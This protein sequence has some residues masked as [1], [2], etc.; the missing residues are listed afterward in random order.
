MFSLLGAN[1]WVTPQ[2]LGLIHD[3][4]W[5]TPQEIQKLKSDLRPNLASIEL[6]I[7]F[8]SEAAVCRRAFRSLTKVAMNVHNVSDA[9]KSCRMKFWKRASVAKVIQSLDF[10]LCKESNVKKTEEKSWK[11]DISTYTILHVYDYMYHCMHVVCTLV[12]PIICIY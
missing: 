6:L 10:F 9:Y 3:Y 12:Y 8:T 4:S 7:R 2:D 11:V 5:G 1:S